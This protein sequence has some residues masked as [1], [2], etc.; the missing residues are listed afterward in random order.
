MKR[1]SLLAALVLAAAL[2]ARLPHAAAQAPDSEY[3]QALQEMLA[4]S[5]ALESVKVMIPQVI[6]MTKPSQPGIPDAFWT[7]LEKEM[8]TK[9]IDRVVD[10]YVPIYQKHLT[11]D[12]LRQI[13]QFYQSPIGRK[14]AGATPAITVEGAQMGAK[15][16]MEMAQEIVDKVRR[17]KEL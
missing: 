10:L 13:N 4:S 16:G 8:R 11:L 7:Q 9:F 14:L 6:A 15:L 12:D 2:F 3:R 1:Q 5:G 17:Y